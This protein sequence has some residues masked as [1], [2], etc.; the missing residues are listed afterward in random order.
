MRMKPR[1]IA[2]R[3]IRTASKVVALLLT[4]AIALAAGGMS[5]RAQA[6]DEGDSLYVPHDSRLELSNKKWSQNDTCG[7][8]SFRK[9]PDYTEQAA[10]KRDAYMRECLRNHHLP[11]RADLA[12]PR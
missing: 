5:A 9:F 2:K 1:Q 12:K 4:G 7:K 6:M 3:K 8:E 10:V 11:P